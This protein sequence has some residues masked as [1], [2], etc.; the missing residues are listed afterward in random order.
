MTHRRKAQTLTIALIVLVLGIAVGRKQFRSFAARQAATPHDTV[1][2]MLD[3]SRAGNTR[4]YLENYAGKMR[5]ALEQS[6]RESGEDRF[7]RYLKETNSAI[8]GIAIS[9]LELLSD[10]EAKLRVEYVYQDRNEAQMMYFANEGGRW[11]I[12][13]VEGTERVKTLVPYGTPVE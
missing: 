13:R 2:A 5:A 11:R 10:R 3:A 9:E 4:A 7:S 12:A 6:V 8:K 1:Y